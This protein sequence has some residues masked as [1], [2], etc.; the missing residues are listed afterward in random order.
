MADGPA[1]VG[2]A[3]FVVGLGALGL[4]SLLESGYNAISSSGSSTTID[5]IAGASA[6][7]PKSETNTSPHSKS[8]S[9]ASLKT[10]AGSTPATPPD[11]NKNNKNNKNNNQRKG[12]P[13]NNQAQNKQVNDIANKLNL[14]KYQRRMLHDEITGM[15]YSFQEIFEIALEIIELYSK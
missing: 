8:T 4:F 12:T 11:P 9:S 6:V 5:G 3:V 7:V 10:I 2:D 1:P 13:G 14:T 15:N